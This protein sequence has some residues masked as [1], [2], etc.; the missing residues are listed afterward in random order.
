MRRRR[1]TDGCDDAAE[2]VFCHNETGGRRHGF[3]GGGYGMGLGMSQ[4]AA[5]GMANTGMNWLRDLAIFL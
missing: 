4:N 2:C 5:N 1:G 3:S